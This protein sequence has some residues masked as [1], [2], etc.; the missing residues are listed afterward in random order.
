MN[1][2]SQIQETVTP[3]SV[4]EKSEKEVEKVVILG[5]RIVS[6]D[7]QSS[8]PITTV[9]ADDISATG[10]M[11][12]DEA[13]V[14][15]PQFGIGSGTKSVGFNASGVATLNLRG[16]GPQRNLVLMDGKR[17]QPSNSQQV[18]DINTIPKAIIN[19]VEVISGG[20]SAVYG[21]DAI[22]GVVNFNL[23]RNF[24]GVQLDTQY[25]TSQEYGGATKDLSLTVG[26]NFDDGRGNLV[27]SASISDRDSI[28]SDKVDF[29]NSYTGAGDF[30]T[31]QGT[32]NPLS[33]S[34]SQSAMDSVFGNYGY[35]A[36]TVSADSFLSFNEDS[37]LFSANNG[38]VNFTGGDGLQVTDGNIAYTDVDSY[39][40]TPLERYTLFGR[41][42]YELTSDIEVYAQFN[43][44]NVETTTRAEAGNT[45]LTI[46]VTN[47]FISDSLS[48]LLASRANPDEALRLEKR[49]IGI[50]PRQN[51]RKFEVYQVQAGVSGFIDT[52][53]GSWQMYGS[54]G[55]TTAETF[56]L[57]SVSRSLMQGILEAD[58]GGT[59]LC[60]GGYNP[61]GLVPVSDDCAKYLSS[62]L[63][64]KTTL[65]QD[66][67]DL[68]FEGHIAELP[69]GE[70]RFAAGI[71]YRANDY[72]YTPDDDIANGTAIGIVPAGA[73]SGSD[74]VIEMYGEVL[75]PLLSDIAL[76]ESLDAGLAYRYAD[77]DLAGSV[78]SYSA[79]LNWAIDDSISIRA[80]YQRAVRAPN[81]GELFIAPTGGFTQI[82]EVVSGGGDPCDMRNANGDS[83]IEALCVAQGVPIELIDT[84]INSQNDIQTT[85]TAN[86]NLEPES[87]DTYTLGFVYN[88]SSDFQ[89]SIDYYS[90]EIEKVIGVTTGTEVLD[91]C[92]NKDGSNPTLS[93]SNYDCSLLTRDTEG[94]TLI[95]VLEPTINQGAYKTRGIDAQFTYMHD[96]SGI[97]GQLKLTGALNH[98]I[99]FDVQ[100]VEGGEFQDYTNTVSNAF[101]GNF[102]SL[103]NLKGNVSLTYM[104]DTWST[105]LRARYI[106]SLKS[107]SKVT[108]SDST[109]A[110]T[111][112]SLAF[113]LFSNWHISEDIKI[114]AG[115]NNL[116]NQDPPVVDGVNGTTEASTYDI[117]GRRL[118]VGLQLNF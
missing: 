40:Q 74:S 60:E 22:A 91:R 56:S 20:A 50:G 51:D 31:G 36:G 117:F 30:R 109:A 106:N 23:K 104:A 103:P 32:Y 42:T 52:I 26:T 43:Y 97:D 16:L 33:N 94:G 108:N 49:F 18:V 113:D 112:A 7:Y 77:Y 41:S 53:D 84:Y 55:S 80:S 64:Q 81:V 110:D 66:I 24:E 28:D 93:E 89:L 114:N 57:N 44:A 1:S 68:S 71:N 38:V 86:L 11:T 13:L 2:Y 29:F 87:A 63:Y 96:L 34:P 37:S 82:G 115:I 39:S 76:A 3:T 107:L 46:P 83:Q 73:S 111:D 6:R 90:I 10:A 12:L 95:N 88:P 5:S 105:G 79:D 58:D 102:G 25:G 85:R 70:S 27:L 69:A 67:L 4:I 47:P 15:L 61:F 65:T 45:A 9:S 118:Y 116:F 35:A 101:A 62:T 75:I 17:M 98:L 14:D 8:S 99:Q 19:S 21:S 72:E 59:S 54:H 100:T 78:S 92:F 48:T